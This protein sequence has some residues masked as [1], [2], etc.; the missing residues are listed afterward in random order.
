MPTINVSLTFSSDDGEAEKFTSTDISKFA[1]GVYDSGEGNPA[2]S[3]KF[4]IADNLTSGIGSKYYPNPFATQATFEDFGVPPGST[5]TTINNFTVDGAYFETNTNGSHGLWIWLR[6]NNVTVRNRGLPALETGNSPWQALILH[7][8]IE[9]EFPCASNTLFSVFARML[10]TTFATGTRAIYYDNINFDIEYTEPTGVSGTGA[11]QAQPATMNGY[12]YSLPT[13]VE[14]VK[15]ATVDTYKLYID[16]VEIPLIKFIIKRNTTTEIAE[17]IIPVLWEPELSA[18]TNI[19]IN[20]GLTNVYGVESVTQLF[21]G[22]LNSYS[23]S[24]FILLG[25]CD[26]AAIYPA[27]IIRNFDNVSYSTDDGNY[28]MYRLQVDPLFYPGDIGMYGTR[29]IN[30]NRVTIYANQYQATMELSD[31]GQV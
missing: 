24:K 31:V 7:T 17:I 30:V 1:D 25:I 19:V 21:T 20:M 8:S 18:A 3:V 10:A 14:P 15:K 22:T 4:D 6:V 13:T 9:T 26:G 5:I 16:G 11:L 28:Y 23:K 29:R 27:N 2:G 12:A